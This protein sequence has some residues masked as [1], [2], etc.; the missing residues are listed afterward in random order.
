MSE[1]VN[2][3]N[4]QIGQ[5]RSWL[6]ETRRVSVSREIER[7]ENVSASEAVEI[8][9]TWE[10][11]ILSKLHQGLVS[12]VLD[13]W[14]SYSERDLA[15]EVLRKQWSDHFQ[16]KVAKSDSEL[17]DAALRKKARK[18]EKRN[19]SRSKS[20]SPH[21]NLGHSSSDSRESAG[22]SNRGAPGSLHGEM[23]AIPEEFVSTLNINHRLQ[24]GILRD[25][26]SLVTTWTPSPVNTGRRALI[27]AFESG[28]AGQR[29]LAVDHLSTAR[30]CFDSGAVKPDSSEWFIDGPEIGRG[31]ACMWGGIARVFAHQS[32]ATA[33]SNDYLKAEAWFGTATLVFLQT[34]ETKMA[35]RAVQEWAEARRLVHDISG[36]TYLF[37]IATAIFNQLGDSGRAK[38]SVI[39]IGK[40]TDTGVD[41][42]FFVGRPPTESEVTLLTTIL[43]G[44][45]STRFHSLLG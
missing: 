19:T 13:I 28:Q 10:G 43:G 2:A 32:S 7:I 1:W 31:H 41:S 9:R 17:R 18:D 37:Q 3:N 35:G 23:K 42:S 39:R 45:N 16:V 44:R 40:N 24:L 8:Y 6:S 38:A 25:S 30:S 33:L 36:A 12:V 4:V 14:M 20:N 22:Q 11:R 15:H 26:S 5:V 21:S 34:G 29:R 27:A